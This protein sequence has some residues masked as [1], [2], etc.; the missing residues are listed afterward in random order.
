MDRMNPACPECGE[1]SPVHFENEVDRVARST[2]G[3]FTPGIYSNGDTKP[4]CLLDWMQRHQELQE[5][6]F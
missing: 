1:S 2:H 6:W 3:Y 4:S 5:G